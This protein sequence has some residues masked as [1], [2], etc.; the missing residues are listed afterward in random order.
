MVIVMQDRKR[1]VFDVREIGIY[2]SA[3]LENQSIINV[4][5]DKLDDC[6]LTVGEYSNERCTEIFEEIIQAIKDGANV[7]EMPE[8]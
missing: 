3:S 6:G 2:E 7:F 1:I 5:V 8:E 4:E